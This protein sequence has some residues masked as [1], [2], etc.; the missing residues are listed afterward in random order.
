[1]QHKERLS[2]SNLIS[3]SVLN[4]E[5][6]EA[7]FPSADVSFTFRNRGGTCWTRRPPRRAIKVARQT[8]GNCEGK[9]N[10]RRKGPDEDRGETSRINH[11]HAFDGAQ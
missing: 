8:C 10:G 6:A 1:M 5:G 4:G 3:S 9:G 7:T 2:I 11:A